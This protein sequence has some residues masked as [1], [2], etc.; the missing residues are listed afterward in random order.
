MQRVASYTECH[1]YRILHHIIA[2][3][4]SAGFPLP[5]RKAKITPRQIEDRAKPKRSRM[6]LFFLFGNLTC[7]L[8]QKKNSPRRSFFSSNC[9]LCLRHMPSYGSFLDRHVPRKIP[10][11]ILYHYYLLLLDLI[12]Q[13]D[14]CVPTSRCGSA[15]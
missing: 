3:I 2:R 9:L 12:L 8:I 14:A 13:L 10:L 4:C 15:S 1:L 5:S 11:P 6:S 7:Y